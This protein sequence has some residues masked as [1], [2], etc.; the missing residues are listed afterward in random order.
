MPEPQ[1]SATSS[2]PS[3]LVKR[4]FA[5]PFQ[6]APR[7]SLIALASIMAVM[8]TSLPELQWSSGADA[9]FAADAPIL[10]DQREV[11]RRFDLHRALM[12]GTR[13]RFES[14][15]R[16]RIDAIASLPEVVSETVALVDSSGESAATVLAVPLRRGE[17]A[18]QVA[19][20]IKRLVPAAAAADKLYFGGLHYIEERLIEASKAQL[21][22]ALLIAGAVLFLL[23]WSVFRSALLALAPLSV[24]GGATLMTLSCIAYAK[25]PIHLTSA[26]IPLFL[27][28][29]GVVGAVHVLSEF[30]DLCEHR[31]GNRRAI[32]VEVVRS[33]LAPMFYATATSAVGFA[34]LAITPISS[35]Q[36]FGLFM[37][38]GV[39]F[40]FV[41][42]VVGMPA[43]VEVMP[44]KTIDVWLGR[45]N[46]LP[47]RAVGGL[48]GSL[49]RTIGYLSYRH[50]RK[51][52]ALGLLL[53]GLGLHQSRHLRIED[54]PLD[55][56]GALSQERIAATFFDTY[57]RGIYPLTLSLYQPK[58]TKEN[59]TKLAD[60]IVQRR[61]SQGTDI[62]SA[63]AQIKSRA[64]AS[65]KPPQSAPE[66]LAEAI[67]ATRQ[68]SASEV[69]I[70]VWSE[71]YDAVT[72]AT[73]RSR[74]FGQTE[75]L[76]YSDRLAD[77]LRQVEGVGR[78]AAPGS[79]DAHNTQTLV[80]VDQREGIVQIHL[81][82]T[83][84]DAV[85]RVVRAVAR[86]TS[87][88]PPPHGLEQ[89]WVGAT[90]LAYAWQD[91][92]LQGLVRGLIA[93]AVMVL[94]LMILLLR[95]PLDGFLSMMPIACSITTV[96]GFL[97][98][99]GY[100]YG[101]AVALLSFMTLGL[102][103]DFSIHFIQRSRALQRRHNSWQHTL[104]GVFAEPARAI[105]RN[106]VVISAAFLPLAWSSL[107]PYRSLGI[108]VP[109][110][111]IL[112]ALATALFVP[113][114][115]RLSR[116]PRARAKAKR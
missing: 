52:L 25:L 58:S 13:G 17:S 48:L 12:V 22:R 91:K 14:A 71:V 24:A 44:R 75:V 105:A 64:F 66:R 41:L 111:V 76:A 67:A 113:P 39:F 59:I 47:L 26:W 90:Y 99:I 61:A 110:I 57:T 21:L 49:V 103:I 34:A 56:F 28:A 23:F 80:A 46:P 33:N 92:L 29:T 18:L 83:D 40:A 10:R 84:P 109:T 11:T 36:T 116:S 86:F 89:R 8:A 88:E 112:S 72:A 35:L 82:T 104:T 102:S 81:R 107:R 55:F 98:S 37:A 68:Q 108:L 20:A 6:K 15:L 16:G 63:W 95:S 94:F 7:L 78:V 27:L 42:V 85:R 114:L 97:V 31:G 3:A 45:K 93:A 106:A 70:A 1:R 32:M 19:D 77:R 100:Q 62:Q 73:K 50:G 2:T 30:V 79:V 51:S 115:M 43:Y 53:S 69:A 4:L 74:A 54:D 87:N 96:Y 5:D 101:L 60:R 65:G 38:L 9:F